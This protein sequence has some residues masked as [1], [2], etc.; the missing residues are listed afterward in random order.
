MVSRPQTCL[1][2]I[3][4]TSPRKRGWKACYGLYYGFGH[5]WLP[6]WASHT[7]VRLFNHFACRIWGH[8]DILWHLREA[9]QS[10]EGTECADCLK[11]LSGC[12]CK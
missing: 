2:V 5:G 10:D 1:G 9:L 3:I 4:S 8:D 11:P 6:R 7:F 12:T